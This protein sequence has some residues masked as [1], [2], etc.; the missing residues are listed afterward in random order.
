MFGIRL[1]FDQLTNGM[2]RRVPTR[3]LKR[4]AL[5]MASSTH[6]W[7]CHMFFF[8]LLF[9]DVYVFQHI[10]TKTRCI[11]WIFPLIAWWFS[12][13]MLVYQRVMCSRDVQKIFFLFSP[14]RLPPSLYYLMLHGIIS[15]KFLGFLG[16]SPGWRLFPHEKRNFFCWQCGISDL[17]AICCGDIPWIIALI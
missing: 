13:V 10:P 5:G 2:L 1:A 6:H 14:P 9:Y 3:S 16:D 17:Q 11:Y 12:I 7:V 4:S 8:R 15:H